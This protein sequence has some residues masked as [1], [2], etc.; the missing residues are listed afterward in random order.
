MGKLAE[1][2]WFLPALTARIAHPREGADEEPSFGF[3][4]TAAPMMPHKRKP[5]AGSSGTV[6][7]KLGKQAFR[8]GVE[9]FWRD[10]STSLVCQV[11]AL[12]DLHL[13]YY[14]GRDQPAH[15]STELGPSMSTNSHIGRT[16]D[17][18]I[19]HGNLSNAAA[20]ALNGLSRQWSSHRDERAL[21]KSHAYV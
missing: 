8:S 5:S 11:V 3:S 1:S 18:P 19:S 2:T 17:T 7:G 10:D 12:D 6:Q 4:F 20:W 16:T 14:W 21:A 9:R 15:A 13:R